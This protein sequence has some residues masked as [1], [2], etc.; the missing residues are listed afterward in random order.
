MRVAER[1]E[2]TA[3][4][5]RQLG[6]PGHR[7]RETVASAVRCMVSE[8]NPLCNRNC[9]ESGKPHPL[10]ISR[11]FPLCRRLVIACR[12]IRFP[13]ERPY[14]RHDDGFS[15]DAAYHPGALRKDFFAR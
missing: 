12:Q 5:Y 4:L 3:F 2:E 7:R 6:W 11:A 14:A 9:P 15:V 8:I 13:P 1:A 10:R